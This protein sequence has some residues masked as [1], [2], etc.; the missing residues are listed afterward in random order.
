MPIFRYNNWFKIEA[1]DASSFKD[2][3]NEKIQ[4]WLSRP[5][6]KKIR[7]LSSNGWNEYS[8]SGWFNVNAR[9]E[10]EAYNRAKKH[11]TNDTP[12][13]Y[14]KNGNRYVEVG[15]LND[16]LTDKDVGY[17]NMDCYIMKDYD[18]KESKCYAADDKSAWNSLRQH[19]APNKMVTLCKVSNIEIKH[20]RSAIAMLLAKEMKVPDGINIEIPVAIGLASEPWWE[21]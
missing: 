3:A 2:L 14:V 5:E 8:V 4:Q 17:Y 19:M 12:V 6:L 11:F 18:D 16:Y 15:D 20:S 10:S 9:N 1:D 21:S 13:I 7:H